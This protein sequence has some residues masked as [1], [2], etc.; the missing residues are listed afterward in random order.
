[1]K[2]FIYIASLRRT[3]STV[4]SEAL[5]LAP[6]SF[7]FREPR[8]G[9][10]RFNVKPDNLEFFMKGGIDLQAF[11]R[12]ISETS[13]SLAVKYFKENLFPELTQLFSQIG[14][15]EIQLKQW[16]NIFQIFPDMKIILT[17]RNQKDIYISHYYR[18]KNG[19]G[20]FM[21]TSPEAVAA[22]LNEQFQK[23]LEM[24]DTADCFKVKYEDLCTNPLVY[25]E[26]KSFVCS[27]IP[28]I[29]SVGN[30]NANNPKRAEEYELHRDCITDKRVNRWQSEKDP[31]L[32]RNAQRAAN[33]MKAYCKF[34]EYEK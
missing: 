26:I 3:G 16:E 2:P 17:G 14:I 23:Q 1:M 34:W 22:H 12:Q 28:K 33:L 20:Q 8:L 10:G 6:H 27:D 32:V 21:E 25:D 5:T 30:F 13:P 11:Q 24:Y 29:G 31:E 4:L 18:V 7:I 19:K 9:S 15:K